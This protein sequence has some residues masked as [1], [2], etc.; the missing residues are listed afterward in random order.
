MWDNELK[1]TAL[2][3]S[4]KKF[5]M[6]WKTNPMVL[7]LTS[8]LV[9]WHNFWRA[10]F[11]IKEEPDPQMQCWHRSPVDEKCSPGCAEWSHSSFL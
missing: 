6:L 2:K 8:I 1:N 7:A 5:L 11:D 4:W 3:C 10:F 9:C